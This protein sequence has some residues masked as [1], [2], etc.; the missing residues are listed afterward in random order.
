[1]SALFIQVPSTELVIFHILLLCAPFQ[2][3]TIT[4]TVLRNDR[5]YH[6]ILNTSIFVQEFSAVPWKSILTSIHVWAIVSANIATDWALYTILIC[7]PTF[8][9]DVLRFDIQAVGEDKMSFSVDE[10]RR[11]EPLRAPGGSIQNLIDRLQS[12]MNF[13]TLLTIGQ[14]SEN[15]MTTNSQ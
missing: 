15:F 3:C 8:L 2:A 13:I 11:R 4:P 12:N 9:L 10:R 7:L 1:M 14:I 5:S 6:T